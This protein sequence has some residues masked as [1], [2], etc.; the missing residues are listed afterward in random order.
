[1]RSGTGG[2][3]CIAW[4]LVREVIFEIRIDGGG[5]EGDHGVGNRSSSGFACVRAG[6]FKKVAD[7]DILCLHVELAWLQGDVV[8]GGAGKS[9]E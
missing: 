6:E 9:W 2:E 1:V 8:P 5:G 4:V 7:A 3:W